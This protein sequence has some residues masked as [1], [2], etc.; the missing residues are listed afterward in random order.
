MCVAAVLLVAFWFSK[1]SAKGFGFC[2]SDTGVYLRAV[3]YWTL[4]GNFPRG[5]STSSLSRV[6]DNHRSVTAS[7][8]IGNENSTKPS[9][10]PPI[11]GEFDR[12]RYRFS[13]Y[14]QAPKE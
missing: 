13:P 4:A 2:S 6:R 5:S 9:S 11:W 8:R 12:D 10:T 1:S 3:S 7:S 14:R